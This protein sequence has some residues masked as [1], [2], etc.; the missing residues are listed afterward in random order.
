MKN[1]DTL[2]SE[3]SGMSSG[4]DAT[5]LALS[6]VINDKKVEDTQK[7][8]KSLRKQIRD[9]GKTIDRI[10]VEYSNQGV[11]GE[12]IGRAKESITKE[13]NES[14]R[15]IY[16]YI[17]MYNQRFFDLIPQPIIRLTICK[18]LVKQ[19][20]KYYPTEELPAIWLD[21]I[22]NNGLVK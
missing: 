3:A 11:S 2:I 19:S 20:T 6:T 16:W 14:P 15:I 5:L 10:K 22:K 8:V 13:F 12:K 1:I 7:V 18:E 9:L 4:L 21:I 17:Q